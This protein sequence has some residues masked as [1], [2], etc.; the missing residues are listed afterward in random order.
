MNGIVFLDHFDRGAAIL[1]QLIN[2]GT[3]HEP[4]A[5]VIMPQRIESV[6]LA[7]SV[8]L[9]IFGLENRLNSLM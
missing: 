2:V 9:Q 7:V 8:E 3:L 4:L 1:G 6:G 5:Y